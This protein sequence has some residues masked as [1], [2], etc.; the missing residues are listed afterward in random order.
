MK[1]QS[2]SFSVPASG[3][4]KEC[5]SHWWDKRGRCVFCGVRI[6]EDEALALTW[7]KIKWE[8]PFD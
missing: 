7:A 8:N 3:D 2:K 5:E 1:Y 4:R 6:S